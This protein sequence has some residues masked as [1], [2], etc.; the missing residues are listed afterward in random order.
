M[1]D[2]ELEGRRQGSKTSTVSKARADNSSAITT[3]D[4]LPVANNYPQGTRLVVITFGLILSIFVAALDSTIIS[5]AIPSI[6]TEFGS[7]SNIAWYGSAYNIT[8]TAFRSSWGKAFKYFPLKPMVLLSI[9]I[10]E[11]GNVICAVAGSSNMLIFGRVVAGIGGGGV[12]TGAFIV[13]ALTV[14]E[15]HRALYMSTVGLTFAVSSVAGPLLGGGLTDS[16]GWRWCFWINLPIGVLA[17]AIMFF[18]FNA[19]LRLPEATLWERIIQMDLGGSALVTGCLTCF[20]LA[21]HWGGTNSWSQPRVILSLFGYCA[22]FLAF[23]AN[24]WWMG[25]K[26]MIQAHLLKN[27]RILSNLG[28][29]FFIAGV[30]FPLQF[31]LPVQFQSVNGTSATQSGI[32][33]I[34]LILGVSVFTTIAG[35][36]L[37]FWRHYEPFLLVGALLATAGATSIYSLGANASTGAWIGTELLTGMGIGL[38]FQMPMIANQADVGHDDIASVTALNL[39]VENFGTT[40]FVA[41]GEAAFT[42]ALMQSLA[43]A[44]PSA[45]PKAVLDVGAT[46]I[47]NFFGGGEL[48]KVLSSYL[49]GCKASHIVCVACG[50]AMSLTSMSTAGPALVKEVRLRLKKS[51]AV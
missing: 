22:F 30:F 35:G 5:T 37:T 46:E 13:I 7:I 17:A 49:H 11:V 34:P 14:K 25:S 44:L 4:G 29:V 40:L 45:D 47:R 31:T 48:G 27:K 36:V 2:I 20:V 15:Q 12:M 43:R 38:A 1:D 19:S 6:T 8:T 28:Y 32:R 41:S 24:S 18:A 9:A 26:S 51:H 10:F 39:F 50:V 16:L 42:K 3:S 21:M 23:V 33:L